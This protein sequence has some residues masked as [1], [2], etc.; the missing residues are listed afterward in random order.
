[1][2]NLFGHW[3]QITFVTRLWIPLRGVSGF[4][5]IGSPT[6]LRGLSGFRVTP[7]LLVP[8]PPPL[9]YTAPY[10]PT[11]LTAMMRQCQKPLMSAMTAT[12]TLSSQGSFMAPEGGPW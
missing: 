7:V 4:R 5:G 2:V 9:H 3:I 6:I 11:V 1:M 10:E 12:M 8:D